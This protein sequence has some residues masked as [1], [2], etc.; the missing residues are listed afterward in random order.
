MSTLFASRR[1][2]LVART[3]RARGVPDSCLCLLRDTPRSFVV[4]V[5]QR[6]C[7]VRGEP[8]A[9]SSWWLIFVKGLWIQ[10]FLFLNIS[11]VFCGNMALY[12][13]KMHLVKK[14]LEMSLKMPSRW[15]TTTVFVQFCV[16]LEL[17]IHAHSSV[18]AKI[19]VVL[20]VKTP[21]SKVVGTR[22]G[23]RHASNALD[24]CLLG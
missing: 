13:I 8:V 2:T 10:R 1:K 23:G 6:A 12:V 11:R 5:V 9:R 22:V 3:R 24:S 20:R 18:R 4:R 21:K 16:C 7:H 19:A 17:G 14:C 15:T